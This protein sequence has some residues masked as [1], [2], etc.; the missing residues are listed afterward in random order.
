MWWNQHTFQSGPHWTHLRVTSIQKGTRIAVG[1]NEQSQTILNQTY[2]RI[3]HVKDTANRKLSHGRGY[4]KT[5]VSNVGDVPRWPFILKIFF[6]SCILS[7]FSERFKHPSH[8]IRTGSYVIFMKASTRYLYVA[9]VML[10]HGTLEVDVL[11]IPVITFAQV[12]CKVDQRHF[13]ES[14]RF[15][16]CMPHM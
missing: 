15:A 7:M 3:Y 10:S 13:K 11:S 16:I 5:M 9:H 6:L 12:V 8:N 1:R 14:R 2:N 4:V